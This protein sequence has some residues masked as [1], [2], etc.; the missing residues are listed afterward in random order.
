MKQFG[1]RTF[2]ETGTYRGDA[3][4]KL[5]RSRSMERIISIELDPTLASQARKRFSRNPTVEIKQGDSALLLPDVVREL[6]DPALFWLDG[7]FSGGATAD[8]GESPVMK[9][10]EAVLS[11]PVP[12]VVLIDDARLFD[13]SDGYPT[14][15]TVLELVALRRPEMKFAVHDD[16]VRIHR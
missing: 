6:A 4:A 12:H 7:H 14:L 13:G 16:I 11:S 10:L 9:E 5:V 15:Q 3:V 1:T 8:S 2:V